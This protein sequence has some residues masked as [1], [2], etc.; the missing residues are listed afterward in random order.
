MKTHPYYSSPELY[1]RTGDYICMNTQ[2]KQ[3]IK[4]KKKKKSAQVLKNPHFVCTLK[5]HSYNEIYSPPQCELVVYFHCTLYNT[6]F[7]STVYDIVS[8]LKLI[9]LLF[10]KSV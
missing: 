5:L 3:E 6:N 7:I 8:G 2:V 4:K 9:K 1:G 10:L